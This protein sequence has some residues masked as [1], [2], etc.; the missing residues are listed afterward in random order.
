[1]ST[2]RD[3]T[4]IVRS[5]LRTEENESADHVLGTVLDRLDTTPQRRAT[6]WPAWRFSEMSTLAKLATAGAAVVVLVVA[7]AAF[8]LGREDIGVEASAEPSASVTEAEPTDEAVPSASASDGVGAPVPGEFTVCVPGNSPL[9]AGT[10]EQLLVPHPEG[11]MTVERTRGYTWAGTHSATDDR[12][13]GTH[14]YSWDGDVYT[15]ASGDDGA[16]VSA[17]SLRIENEDGAWQGSGA[18]ADLPD[19]TSGSSPL[20][21]TGEGTYEGLTAVLLWVDGPC[22]LDLRGIVTEFPDP[23][24]PATSP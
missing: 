17:E 20:V 14:Y 22:F 5:W 10:D 23:P 24:V 2:D 7:G 19:G 3:T 6:A 16:R 13:S 1:M 15:L 8:L 18:S 21:M 4:R 9:R 11:D 12:F